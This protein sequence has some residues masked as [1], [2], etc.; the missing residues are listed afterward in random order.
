VPPAA[1]APDERSTGRGVERIAAP[2]AAPA[3][4]LLAIEDLRVAFG[5][6]HALDGVSFDL[7]RSETLGLIGPN[8]AGKTTVFNC[9][10]RVYEPDAGAIRLDGVD[11]LAMR[12]GRLRS[13]LA[14]L[15]GA[16]RAASLPGGAGRAARRLL[17]PGAP[18][19]ALAGRGVA[20]TFQSPALFSTLSVLDN[21]LLGQH[22]TGSYPLA[23]AALSLGP[24]RAWERRA[25]E[26]AA[27]L[28]DRLA[29]SALAERPAGSLSFPERKRVELARALAARP[30]LLL[31]DEPASGLAHE[32]VE[33]LGAL[34]RELRAEFGLTVLLVEHHMGLVAA[35]CDRVVVLDFGRV[36]AQGTPSAIA[37][38]P[39]VIEAYLGEPAPRERGDD[40]ADRPADAG[41]AAAG[42]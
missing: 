32:E 39:A 28:L 1:H 12:G 30:S 14:A 19:H 11:L 6:I 38:D 8:G 42:S 26:R 13:A 31:M 29:L 41:S 20:R 18:A 23:A 34:I 27:A 37:R 22:A 17:R 15:P 2:H 33:A 36:I 7:A 21:V 5:G 3:R 24:A 35:V 4:P 16:D 9:I 25:R 40:T 10:T